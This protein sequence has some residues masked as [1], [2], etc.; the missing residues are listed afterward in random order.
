MADLPL[1]RLL[2]VAVQPALFHEI[3]KRRDE[4]LCPGRMER[5]RLC[6]HD[7]V[8]TFRVKPD[9]VLSVLPSDG[10]LELVAV[11]IFFLASL[12]CRDGEIDAGDLL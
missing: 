11:A 5:T 10:E 6:W 1:A 3:Q 8:R 4:P 9:H 12:A 2:V 7:S